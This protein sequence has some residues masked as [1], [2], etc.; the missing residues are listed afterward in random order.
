MNGDYNIEER[1]FDG[2]DLLRRYFYEDALNK[3]AIVQEGTNSCYGP[4]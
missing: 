4:N 3:P 2:G 1:N